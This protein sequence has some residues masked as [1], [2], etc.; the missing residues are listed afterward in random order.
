MKLLPN[1]RHIVLINCLI[2]ISAVN[3]GPPANKGYTL[4]FDESFTDD[5]LN[6]SNWHYRIGTRTG[7]GIDGLNLKENVYI[8]DGIL[9]IVA[10]HE[11]IN[12][13]SEY[14]GGGIITKNDFGY[15]YYETLSKPFMEGRGVHTSFW[16]RGSLT[17]NNT[18]FEIDSYEIDS[19]SYMACN[20]LYYYIC[21]AGYKEYPW[22]H[23]ANIP[24]QF[25]SD[26]WFLDAYER[27]PEG[28]I[29]YDNGKVVAKAEW[30]ELNAAQMVWLTALNGVGKV[31]TDKLPGV[32]KFKYFRFYAKDYPGYN[33]L[34]NGNFEFNQDKIPSSKPVSWTVTGTA[35]VVNVV[36]GNAS[37]DNYKLLITGKADYDTK[38]SQKL[39]YIMNGDYVLTAMT[40]S[41]GGQKKAQLKAN[42]FG[43]NEIIAD[44][45]KNSTWTKI[46]IP[47][48]TVRNNSINIE[49]EGAGSA[50]QWL[51]IDDI[52]LM[53]PVEAGQKLPDP[54]PFKTLG[55]P[56]YE[57]AK[58]EPI[59][60]TGD[61]AFY[62]FAR[63]VGYG[64]A[65]SVSFTLTADIMATMTPIA[66]IPKT[67][68]SGWAIQFNENGSLIFRI[69]S[70]EN[71]TDVLATDVYSV[72]KPV[73]V[74]CVFD[75]GSA[76]IYVDGKLRKQVDGITQLTKDATAA[77]RLGAVGSAYSDVGDVVLP[78]ATV[79]NTNTN[80]KRFRGSIQHLKIY[81]T[82]IHRNSDIKTTKK[83]SD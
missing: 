46:T 55:E 67:G 7:L 59:K 25:N 6:T 13:K 39:S 31:D 76:R 50:D 19:K 30:D 41:S 78:D 44:I 71:H 15:G 2:L 77:G 48:V 23:R 20:N 53:K 80:M 3:A 34:P 5:T 68:S 70:I 21:P 26:G 45:G 81:N 82:A 24:F 63:N 33:L 73:D 49:I 11:V 8:K 72:G 51:E 60:F 37:R 65:I 79:I 75:H 66:R 28:I 32:S 62:F 52:N 17:P 83:N 40:R 57:L 27:T 43:G 61:D 42:G 22:P 14:T 74:N 58:K 54:V 36:K 64:D 69:G 10:K 16:Q 1:F 4:L 29:F 9:H 38:L 47:K 35:D 12:G 18:I 56:I